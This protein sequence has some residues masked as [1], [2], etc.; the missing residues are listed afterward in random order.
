MEEEVKDSVS[1]QL[2]IVLE[3]REV[4]HVGIIGLFGWS[5]KRGF[6]PRYEFR[7]AALYRKS[8]ESHSD[9]LITKKPPFQV[10]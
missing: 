10:T 9:I 1:K 6:A 3:W 5:Q 4:T 7:F 2:S 8:F